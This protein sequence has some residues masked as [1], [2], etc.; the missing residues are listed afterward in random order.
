M[1]DGLWQFPEWA[2]VIVFL[3]GQEDVE[4]AAGGIKAGDDGS[5]AGFGHGGAAGG[6]FG[7]CGPPDV[8]K[9]GG[10]FSGLHMGWRVVGDEKLER[11][12]RIALFHLLFFL[13]LGG[14]RVIEDHVAIVVR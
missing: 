11:V 7:A 13:P 6:G 1:V 3:A 2:E 9:D 5:E 12:G 10:A 14:G 4:R 8:E